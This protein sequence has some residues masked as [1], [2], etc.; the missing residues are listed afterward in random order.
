MEIH[1]NIFFKMYSNMHNAE[2]EGI[3]KHESN[4]HYD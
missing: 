2:V 4:A 3:A 1:I